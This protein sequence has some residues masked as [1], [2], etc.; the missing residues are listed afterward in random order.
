MNGTTIGADGFLAGLS[1]AAKDGWTPRRPTG[2]P[3][4]THRSKMHSLS[5]QFAFA[6]CQV[7]AEARLKHE[8]TTLHPDYCPAFQRPGLVTFKAPAATIRPDQAPAAVFA[9]A[10]GCSGGPLRSPDEVPAWVQRLQP[11]RLFLGPRTPGTTVPAS[12]RTLAATLP[13]SPPR[14][15]ELVLDIIT[16]DDEPALLGWH[17][18]GHGRH[19]TPSGLFTFTV[20][21]AAPSRA[22]G[23]AVEG[24][25]W[26]GAPVRA[27][28][29]LV[30][31]GAAPGGTTLAY[32]E[33]DLRV[34]AIDTQG[35]APV[36]L[37]HPGC[38]GWI[39]K[40]IGEVALEELPA[41]VHWLA[42]DAGI[43]PAHAVRSLRRLRLHYRSTLRGLL[44]TL[45]LND[46]ATV[47]L[48]PR[49]FAELRQGGGTVD[50]IQLPTNRHDL[51]V[52]V[53]CAAPRPPFRRA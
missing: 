20:P 23:K 49:L 5:S 19:V 9:R 12:W 35:M 3:G 32:L 30:E 31:I 26:S 10:W 18:H 24:L 46:D 28:N 8:I 53:R 7:G 33:R 48:L 38:L 2:K 44:L 14:A 25:L 39:K 13:P 34:L 50:A 37:R 15:G 29:V 52:Y 41:V 11:A 1:S 36:I 45:K 17:L 6:L 22:Y 40:P 42:L 21:E 51:F 47:A 27:G 16:A 43:A 4:T